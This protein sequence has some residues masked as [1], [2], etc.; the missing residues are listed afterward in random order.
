MHLLSF[1]AVLALQT[2]S[3]PLPSQC[4]GLQVSL[5]DTVKFLRFSSPY[6][7]FCHFCLV[8]GS[9]LVCLWALCVP[10]NAFLSAPPCSFTTWG[11]W[12]FRARSSPA[13]TG[14]QTEQQ[15]LEHCKEHY[16]NFHSHSEA[17]ICNVLVK[18]S[19]FAWTSS[20]ARGDPPFELLSRPS[21]ETLLPLVCYSIPKPSPLGGGCME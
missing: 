19:A 17:V 2:T 5:L 1:A 16:K 3:L 13:T 20:I 4:Q 21:R 9:A 12:C 10:Y 8:L 18:L 14:T 11:K 6:Q 7:S 15:S